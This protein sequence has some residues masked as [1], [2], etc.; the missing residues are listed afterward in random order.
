MTHTTQ[1]VKLSGLAF[2]PVPVAATQQ[3]ALLCQPRSRVSSI[4]RAPDVAGAKDAGHS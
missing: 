4:R 1:T 2:R 3:P